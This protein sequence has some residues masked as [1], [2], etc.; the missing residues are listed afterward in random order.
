MRA[1]DV[2]Y[3]WEGD[4]LLG[5]GAQEALPWGGGALGRQHCLPSSLPLGSWPWGG[6]CPWAPAPGGSLG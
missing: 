1:G 4:V 6:H 3:S 5:L 2:D